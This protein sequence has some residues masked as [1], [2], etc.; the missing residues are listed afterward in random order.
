MVIVQHWLFHIIMRKI[1]FVFKFACV[2]Y[3][4]TMRSIAFLG[5]WEKVNLIDR[6]VIHGEM[7]HQLFNATKHV[8]EA[9]SSPRGDVC[10]E[11]MLPPILADRYIQGYI[12]GTTKK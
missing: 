11:Y 1:I 6:E 3:M 9:F 2:L 12:Y 4:A 8:R 5:Q 7:Q 10:F